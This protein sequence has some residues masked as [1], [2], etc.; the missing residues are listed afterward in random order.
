MPSA[1]RLARL[2]SVVKSGLTGI[3]IVISE[4]REDWATWNIGLDQM[5]NAPL[6]IHGVVPRQLI[7]PFMRYQITSVD[8]PC[9]L[10]VLGVIVVSGAGQR[11]N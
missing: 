11:T 1:K 9:K 8:A 5:V 7:L 2:S 4:D 6:R 3:S 10:V